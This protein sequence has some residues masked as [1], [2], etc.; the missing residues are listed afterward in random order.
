MHS[1]L[2]LLFANLLALTTSLPTPSLDRRACT[3]ILPTSYQLISAA[4]P[5]FSFPQNRNFYTSTGSFGSAPIDTLIHFTN[6]PFGA[7]GCQLAVSFTDEY[8]IASSG[9]TQLSVYGLVTDITAG[10]TYE[11]YFPNGGGGE[12]VGSLGLF[13]T[14]TLNGQPHVVNSGVCAENM[15]FLFEIASQTEA[16]NVGFQDA[17]NNL[18]GIGGFYLT[19]DC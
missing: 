9:A 4:S 14:V 11:E 10:S 1:T 13:G 7:Y 6:I 2:L 15:S 12:P 5:T 8:P 18:S 3:T 16:G 17:G 19:F